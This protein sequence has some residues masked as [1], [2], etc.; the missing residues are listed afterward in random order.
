MN[1]WVRKSL[2]V[3][4]LSAGF[5]LVASG[6]AHA[7]S[8]TGNNTGA[9]DGNQLGTNGQAPV[10]MDGNS[11]GFLGLSDAT[12]GGSA[13][14]HSGGSAGH[15]G[16]HAAAKG[17]KMATGNSGGLITGNQ[18]STLLQ[19]PVNAC[20]N[21]IAVLGIADASCGGDSAA[22][23]PPA[24]SGSMTTGTN[25]GVASGNQIG[26]LLQAPINACG[27]S[28]AV[29]GSATASCGGGA[30]DGAGG[31]TGGYGAGSGAAAAQVTGAVQHITQSAHLQKAATTHNVNKIAMTHN[32]NK[33]AKTHNVKKAGF[34]KKNNEA[35]GLHA[36]STKGGA[37]AAGGGGALTTG[38]NGGILTGN[39]AAT[40]ILA[41]INL[42][43]NA[44]SVLGSA[45]A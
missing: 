34:H 4:V 21:S 41:P 30:G 13:G 33:A 15:G 45:N 22:A 7:D 36:K 27:N 29:L 17:T 9:G 2:N 20:G 40:S 3:G 37:T 10:T 5:L 11:V 6:A 43:G 19:A 18:V 26:T 24:G 35:A 44:I 32:V 39:Q 25:N 14:A 1:T 8:V 28:I 23:E 31:S 38:N 12:D 16:A 42:S